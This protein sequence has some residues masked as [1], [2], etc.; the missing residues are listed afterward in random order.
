MSFFELSKP[1]TATSYPFD[2]HSHL[3]GIL[4]VRLVR[5]PSAKS[6]PMLSLAE[7]LDQTDPERGEFLLFKE[8][9]EFMLAANPFKPLIG[10]GKG[11]AADYQRGE[12]VAENIYVASVLLAQRTHP[13]DSIDALPV[14]DSRLYQTAL[15]AIRP[16]MEQQADKRDPLLLAFV[17]YFNGKIYSSNKYTPFDDVYKARFSLVD[18]IGGAK[19]Q[20]EGR[21]QKWLEATLDYLYSEGIRAIQIAAS[22]YDIPALDKYIKDFNQKK[23]TSY[24]ALV[25]TAAG[26]RSEDALEKDLGVILKLLVDDEHTATVGLDLL[27]TENKVAEYKVLFEFLSENARSLTTRF[28]EGGRAPRMTV[29]IHNGEGNVSGPNNRS[30]IGYQL[31]YGS[32]LPDADFYGALSAYIRRCAQ[33]TGLRQAL[34]GRGVLGARGRKRN[35]VSGLFDELFRHNA[36]TYRGCRLRRFDINEEHSRALVAYNAKRSVMG[37]SEAFDVRA[38]EHQFKSWYAALTA[39][40]FPYAFRLGHDYYYRNYMAARYP[41][42]AFDTNLGSNAVT[43][44]AGWFGSVESY[45]INR[46]FRHLDGYIETDVLGAAATAVAYMASGTLDVEQIA[47]FLELSKSGRPLAEELAQDDTAKELR[48]MLKQALGTVAG[49]QQKDREEYY[50]LY[51]DLV[52]EIVGPHDI[53]F[54]RYQA[55]T[56][57]YTLFLNWRSY[58]L[59]ADGQGAEHTNIQDE[60]LRMLILLA[61]ELMPS[62]LPNEKKNK[63][64][65]KWLDRM[66]ELLQ[67]LLL[68]IAAIYWQ[69]TMGGESR[70][71]GEEN[72]GGAHHQPERLQGAGIGARAAPP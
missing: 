68:K 48:A 63:P 43:G 50:K 12:C 42:L 29:H 58:L 70:I 46:G 17:R 24:R 40:G 38:R 64:E 45:R 26:Y 13:A 10:E 30:L 16:A 22:A 36:L 59:G 44:A 32:Q 33:A 11:N 14:T 47:F 28:K 71:V 1:F 7:W 4:P 61:Y 37:L 5:Q 23:H 52:L 20:P 69:T 6:Y 18:R 15:E 39:H 2:Y 72:R 67:N 66:L 41:A 53:R 54:F 49:D 60:F 9:L 35:G 27:G 8:A 51:R 56:R 55:L 21:Y 62:S 3:G 19:E 25:H 57:V 65:E 34:E 31:L